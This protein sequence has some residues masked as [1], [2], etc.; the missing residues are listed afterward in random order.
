MQ[1]GSELPYMEMRPWEL[2]PSTNRPKNEGKCL[3]A[4]RLLQENP[5]WA[6]TSDAGTYG[7]LLLDTVSEPG[8]QVHKIQQA[9]LR[10]TPELFDSVTVEFTSAEPIQVAKVRLLALGDFFNLS[11][12]KKMREGQNNVWKFALPE[13]VLQKDVESF[14]AYIQT[15]KIAITPDNAI[16]LF[17]LALHFDIQS[18]GK[19]CAR[20]LL[21]CLNEDITQFPTLLQLVASRPE[22][23]GF[24]ADVK[25]QIIRYTGF[26]RYKSSQSALATIPPEKQPDCDYLLKLG[27]EACLYGCC[28]ELDTHGRRCFTFDMEKRSFPCLE[29]IQ[30]T[31][32]MQ[33][34]IA[35]YHLDD[36]DLRRISEIC[37]DSLECLEFKF[38]CMNNCEGCREFPALVSL[39]SN[40]SSLTNK[41]LEHISHIAPKLEVLKINNS[42][43]TSVKGCKKFEMLHTLEACELDLDDEEVRHL[44]LLAPNLQELHLS[45]NKLLRDF[46][47]CQFLHLLKLDLSG[48][49]IDEWSL[50]SLAAVCGN[51]LQVLRIDDCD[52]ASF[53][54][55]KC[56]F[57]NLRE[58]Y[59]NN[60]SKKPADVWLQNISKYLGE[61]LE[62]LEV[63][64]TR[65]TSFAGCYFPKL[66]RLEADY[67]RLTNEGL[68]ALSK[69][70][71]DTLEELNVEDCKYLVPEDFKK[72]FPKLIDQ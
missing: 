54:E 59:A 18:L 53:E 29:K 25:C 63:I 48:T 38:N 7:K 68:Q 35:S 70:A 2:D 33:A 43:I 12:V 42:T 45:S 69:S 40:Y 21:E 22:Y 28:V 26:F 56:K 37:G 65:I 49:K 64:D 4:L 41:G 20:Y 50:Q 8:T 46:T 55:C 11:S 1:L 13:D 44:S 10:S 32:G 36:K 72:Y 27:E 62:I 14:L 60:F 51:H 15:G 61:R 57:S 23:H 9:I 5:G 34:I 71:A 17:D 47:G 3:A 30:K 52:S 66:R 67:T 31:C 39:D 16:A 58:L 19:Q 24:V 6:H